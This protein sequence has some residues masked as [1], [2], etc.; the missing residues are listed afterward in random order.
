MANSNRLL[1]ST[2]QNTRMMRIPLKSQRRLE[3]A[4]NRARGQCLAKSPLHKRATLMMMKSLRP[5]HY[6]GVLGFGC[7][8][9]ILESFIFS[10]SP[11]FA[12]CR[13][14]FITSSSPC[15]SIFF[16]LFFFYSQHLSRRVLI[17]FA[18]TSSFSVFRAFFFFFI[19]ICS[20]KHAGRS[21]SPFFFG[22]HCSKLVSWRSLC[23]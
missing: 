6:N 14:T 1:G 10:P 18:F 19:L 2:R 22:T 8:A 9:S 21:M 3:P 17:F 12:P 23:S 4:A 13:P 16:S 15:F 5:I 11:T 7:L 20:W